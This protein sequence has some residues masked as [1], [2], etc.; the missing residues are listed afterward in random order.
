MGNDFL[1]VMVARL[2]PGE[3]SLLLLYDLITVHHAGLVLGLGRLSI[4]KLRTELGRDHRG[5]RIA[6]LYHLLISLVAEI[7]CLEL[8]FVLTWF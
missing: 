2:R 5:L 3:L 6:D 4:C 1:I 7:L 8:L